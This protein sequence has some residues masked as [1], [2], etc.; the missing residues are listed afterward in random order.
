MPGWLRESYVE[1]IP[2]LEAGEA[3]QAVTV[4]ALGSG[5]VKKG[6]SSRILQQWR[7]AAAGPQEARGGLIEKLRGHGFDIVIEK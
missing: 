3:L 1:A 7:R 6:E 5:M 2:Q 4:A